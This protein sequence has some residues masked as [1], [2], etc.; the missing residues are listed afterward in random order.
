MSHSHTPP[1]RKRAPFTAR[2]ISLRCVSSAEHHT[3]E[4]YCKTGRTKPRHHLPRSDLSWNTR[5]VSSRY[6]VIE[7]LLWKLSEYAF[8][9]HLQIKCHSQY[10]KVIRLLQYSSAKWLI[11]WWLG[12]HWAWPGDYYSLGVTRIQFH[13]SKVTSLSGPS[14][15]TDQGLCYCNSNAWGWHNSHQSE[16]IGIR[17]ETLGWPL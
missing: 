12:M 3:A 2:F 1:V 15:V 13:S 6:Q 17:Y 4:Q 5:Q 16:V 9:R 8:Q 11:W 14:K 10:I 7:K